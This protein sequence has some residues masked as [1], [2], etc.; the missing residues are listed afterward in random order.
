MKKLKFVQDAVALIRDGDTIAS[1]G[2]V[3]SGHPEYLTWAI[4][5][6]FLNTGTPR[7]LTIV[8]AAGQGDGKDKGINHLAHEGLTRRVIGGHWNLAPKMGK[9]AIENKIEAYNFPQGVIS[10]LF[11]DIAAGKPGTVTHVGLETFIDPR[12][13]GGKLNERTKED[14]VAIVSLEGKE[15]LL[16][17]RI[18]INVGLVR[19]TYSD[20]NG[21]ISMEKEAFFGEML[22]IAQAAK[23]CGGIVIAQVEKVLHEKRFH[24]KDVRIPGIVVDAVVEAPPEFHQQ[25]F[26]CDYNPGYSG[27]S[28]VPIQKLEA[29]PFDERK[30]IA[31]RALR[32]ISES[33][34]VNLGIGMPEG[35]ARVAAEEGMDQKFTLTVESGPIGGIPAGGLNF[36]ASLNPEAIIEQPSQFDFYDGGG[37]DVACLG[38]AQANE[39]G[40]VNVSAFENRI[41]G[42]GGFVNISQNAKKIVFCGTFTTLGLEVKIE[43][44]KLHIHQEGAKKKFVQHIQQISFSGSYASKRRQPVLF[45]TERAVFELTGGSLHLRE[46]V[47]GIELERDILSQ[48]EFQPVVADVRPMDSR[49]FR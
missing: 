12:G 5:Q 45:V 3:G 22:A 36:G 38:F 39:H 9:L 41:A 7:N 17:K 14:L 30:V 40:D 13:H 44:G 6:R 2:F 37:I 42:V 32:E 33:A 25:T 31:R 27:E 21:N 48:M 34:I 10:H 15:W 28:L 16:Y 47:P 20:A 46:I 26:A 23:N 8:Y 19:G 49:L 43:G 4:E 11:R 29:M 18:P 35:V 24:P 1:G